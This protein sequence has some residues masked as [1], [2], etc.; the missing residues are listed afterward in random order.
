[1][2]V[3][4]A[5][6]NETE[7]GVYAREKGLF[8]EQIKAWRDIC[9]SAN[10]GQAQETARM[11]QELKASGKERKK[12]KQELKTKRKGFGRNSGAVGTL[13]K[14][15]GDLGGSQRANDQRLRS[16]ESNPAD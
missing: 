7:L 8:V 10:G 2:V 5:A 9:M 15:T 12:L 14:S 16:H 1:M 3:E 13:K 11:K 4:T 6:M